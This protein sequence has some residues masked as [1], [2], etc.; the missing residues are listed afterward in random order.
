MVEKKQN[1]E[2]FETEEGN[3]ELE[4]EEEIDDSEIKTKR[5]GRPPVIK[6]EDFEKKHISVKDLEEAGKIIN[7]LTD[8]IKLEETERVVSYSVGGAITHQT[9]EQRAKIENPEFEI[10]KKTLTTTDAI[11]VMHRKKDK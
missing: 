1:F 6:K 7:K 5:R 10:V 2:E 8:T 11:F 9:A 3:E 4:T